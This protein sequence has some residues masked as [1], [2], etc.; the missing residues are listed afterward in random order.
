MDKIP[1]TNKQVNE[2]NKTLQLEHR[3]KIPFNLDCHISFIVTLYFYLMD[4]FFHLIK[5][6]ILIR[7]HIMSLVKQ[8]I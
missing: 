5:H 8:M 2:L 3:S 1:L 6:L 7:S 4:C